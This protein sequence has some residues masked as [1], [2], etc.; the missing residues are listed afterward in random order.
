MVDDDYARL[1][2]GHCATNFLKR[3]NLDGSPR[4]NQK[5]V[6]SVRCEALLYRR[7]KGERGPGGARLCTHCG[8]TYQ[9]K[10]HVAMYC[11]KACKLAAHRAKSQSTHAATRR[12][13]RGARQAR[14]LQLAQA[15]AVRE[16][17]AIARRLSARTTLEQTRAAVAARC[18]SPCQVCFSPVGKS[19]RKWCSRACYRRS[20]ERRADKAI[21]KAKRRAR[22][23]TLPCERFSPLRVFERDGWK[24]RI[25]GCATPRAK[26]GTYD[27][28]APELD[29]VVP[30]AARGHH[31]M[32][33]TQCACR[34][35]NGRKGATMPGGNAP[36]GGVSVFT[37]KPA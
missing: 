23:N 12:E 19:N 21:D 36:S 20:S 1:S 26:R 8:A 32:S 3:L 24:C 2:C 28:D 11:R 4:K 22:T 7:A 30:L 14:A 13:A 17:E 37:C 25:C 31:T 27:N 10:H 35:C 29:H 6:C 33:N 9:P 18:L 34:R 5:K 16:A 15:R